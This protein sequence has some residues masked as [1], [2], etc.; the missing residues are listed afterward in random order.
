MT[1]PVGSQVE[2]V[3]A[4]PRND[5]GTIQKAALRAQLANG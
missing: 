2:V 5:L 4:I 1:I 3:A